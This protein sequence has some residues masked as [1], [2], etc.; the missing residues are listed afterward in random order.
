ME[1]PG[2]S[3]RSAARATFSAYRAIP[4][5]WRLAGGSAALTFIIL[6]AFAALVGVLTARQVRGSFNNDVSA[7][8]SRLAGEL[9]LHWQPNGS[10][11]CLD[12]NV[13]LKD[14]VE[15]EHAQIRVYSDDGSGTALC[16]QNQVLKG[17]NA[18]TRQLSPDFPAPFGPAGGFQE[19][20]YRVVIKRL[21]V[22]GPGSEH[23]VLL[24]YARPLSDLDHTIAKIQFFV[25]LG[26]LGGTFLALLAGLGTAHRGIR[27]LVELADEAR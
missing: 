14:F 15:A 1:S 22:S 5:R 26:V 8:A 25:L 19:L 12:T 13:A 9:H 24:L 7:T 11:G 20:G 10:L 3:I 4:V 2:S 23:D 21:R 16:T 18:R 27:P 6:A 17:K